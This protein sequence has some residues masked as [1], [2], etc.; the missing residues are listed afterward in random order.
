MSL[1]LLKLLLLRSTVIQAHI[2]NEQ[3]RQAPNVMRLLKLKRLRLLIAGRLQ[4]LLDVAFEDKRHFQPV[5]VLV[6][7]KR[8]K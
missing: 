2:E 3:K 5:P 1:R 6:H 8:Y 7:K 4:K